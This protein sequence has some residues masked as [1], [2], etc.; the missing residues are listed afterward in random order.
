MTA[1][2]LESLVRLWQ[3]R[4]GLGGWRL[5]VEVETPDGGNAATASP[6]RYSDEAR[7]RFAP[8]LLG[9]AE[10]PA[11]VLPAHDDEVEVVVVH[12]L[13]HLALRDLD[14][15]HEIIEGHLH[16]D[17]EAVF[18]AG[19]NAALERSIER[20]SLALVRSWPTSVDAQRVASA[21]G[22]DPE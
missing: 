5:V 2:Q 13:L 15:G 20:L 19:Q 16:R 17:V 7:L 12:E 9:K 10:R 8:W 11:E 21:Y 22:R 3:E 6:T 4:L 14:R 1:K 18:L